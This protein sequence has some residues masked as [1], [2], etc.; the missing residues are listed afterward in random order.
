MF[1]SFNHF[2]EKELEIKSMEK[3]VGDMTTH[4]NE[5]ETTLSEI[6]PENEKLKKDLEDLQEQTKRSIAEASE[7]AEEEI[8]CLKVIYCIYNRLI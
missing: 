3:E 8:R 2:Q 7:N 6:E 4:I 1:Q 5:C